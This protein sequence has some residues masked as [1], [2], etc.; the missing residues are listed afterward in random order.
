MPRLLQALLGIAVLVGCSPSAGEGRWLTQP[1]NDQHTSLFFPIST[2]RIHAIGAPAVHVAGIID[3]NSC[4]GTSDSFRG[5]DCLTCHTPTPTIPNHV[6]N[7]IAG[8]SYDSPSCY[9]CHP[10]GIGSRL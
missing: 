7:K 3:C 9:G 10:D 6:Q 1:T 4:H 8:F 2:G 5:F